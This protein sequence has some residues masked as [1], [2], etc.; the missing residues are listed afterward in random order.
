MLIDLILYIILGAVAGFSAGLFGLGGGV[1]IVPGLIWVFVQ[2][3][4]PPSI[5]MHLAQGC[6]MGTMLFTSI[7]SSYRHHKL[8][9]I[10]WP[11]FKKLILYVL[12]GVIIGACIAWWLHG[13]ILSIIFAFYLL[14]V[15]MKMLRDK[16]IHPKNSNNKSTNDTQLPYHHIGGILI[17]GLSGL[18]GIG[19]GTLSVPFLAYS[20]LNIKNAIGTS[21]AFTFPIAVIGT[22]AYIVFGYLHTE[23]PHIPWTTGFV[24]WPAVIIIGP[25]SAICA[26]FGAKTTQYVP[27]AKLKKYF[28]YFVLLICAS[29]IWHIILAFEH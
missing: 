28:G 22:I 19:G 1:V 15:A 6:S 21:S 27:A 25:V 12:A 18:L 10:L 8:H 3:H 7:S 13:V 23:N 9:N 26:Q 29:L 11:A 16:K 2:L 24:Y 20:K 4:F 17:G 14:I 5:K